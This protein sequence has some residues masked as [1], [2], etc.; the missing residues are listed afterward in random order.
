[1]AKDKKGNTKIEYPK[2][3]K[4]NGKKVR[5]LS[6]EDEAKLVGT[7]KNPGWDKGKDK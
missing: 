6:A 3:I 5:V 2:L 7:N 4:I 1:M